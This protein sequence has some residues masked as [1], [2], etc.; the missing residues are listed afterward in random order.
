MTSPA[1]AGTSA[2]VA[3]LGGTALL[4][5]LVTWAASIG[6][7]RVVSGGH[8]ERVGPA[9]PPSSRT[10]S[11]APKDPLQEARDQKRGE[12]PR[13]LGAIAFALEIL[14]VAVV[15]F[16]VGRLLRRLRQAWL[17]RT[18]R[19]R[20]PRPEDVDFE[21]LGSAAQVTEVMSEDAEEQ[22]SLL[23]IGGEPRNAIVECWQRFEQQ[24]VRAGVERRTW[25]TTAEFVLG[26]LD[27]VGADRGAVSRLA[28]LYREARFSDHPMTDEHR[29]A[30]LD[31]L[32]VIHRS[33]RPSRTVAR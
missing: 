25:Q 20:R 22:R 23:A 17:S 12:P 26:M 33:L 13:W 5:V 9:D 19:R 21:V 2:V 27:L 11:A 8:V 32:D 4:L 6:P 30:A 1:R 14:T 15:L 29:R 7:D 10:P 24:A 16:L 18:R 3:V 28:D 31:A